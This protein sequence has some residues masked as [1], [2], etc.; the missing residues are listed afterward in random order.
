MKKITR[1]FFL[2]RYILTQKQNNNKERL[3]NK[4]TNH[5]QAPMFMHLSEISNT[6][7][8][9]D[10]VKSPCR[11]RILIKHIIAKRQ[12]FMQTN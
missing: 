8:N 2:L 12:R 6:K 3:I 11:Y 10:Y 1:I 4:S 7:R 9:D 5:F